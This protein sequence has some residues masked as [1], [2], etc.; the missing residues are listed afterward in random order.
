MA[1]RVRRLEV[2]AISPQA[3]MR[4]DD[5]SAVAGIQNRSVSLPRED[6]RKQREGDAK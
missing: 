3:F 1:Q 5:V 6:D 2:D 4:G